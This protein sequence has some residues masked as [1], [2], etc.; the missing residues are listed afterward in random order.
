MNPDRLVELLPDGVKAQS[1]YLSITPRIF[2]DHQEMMGH[3]LNDFQPEQGWLVFQSDV[4]FFHAS[5]PLVLPRG[6]LL[7]GE[8]KN[9]AEEGLHIV[10]SGQGGWRVTLYQEGNEQKENVVVDDSR[11]LAKKKQGKKRDPFIHYRRYWKY[12]EDVGFHIYAARFSGFTHEE[13]LS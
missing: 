1:C 7:N 9:A 10:E 2:L 13:S 5:K 12:T 11:M 4:V 6:I 3:I 8:L